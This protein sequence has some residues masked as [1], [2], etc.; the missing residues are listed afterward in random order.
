MASVCNELGIPH[1]LVH[2]QPDPLVPDLN[3][4]GHTRNFFPRSSLFSAVLGEI[5]TGNDWKTFTIVYENNDNLERMH[6]IL[7]QHGPTDLPVTVHQLPVTSDDYKPLLKAIQVSGANNIILD[8]SQDK[9]MQ[10]LQQA[11]HVKIL[12]DYE[13]SD[14]CAASI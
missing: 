9:I 13:V 10:L 12:E 2:W 1:I 5:I 3:T 11:D 14:A 4:H 8:C 6:D 7:Q